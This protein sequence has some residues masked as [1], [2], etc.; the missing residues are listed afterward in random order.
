METSDFEVNNIEDI[1]QSRENEE[2]FFQRLSAFVV[3]TNSKVTTFIDTF[4]TKQKGK[5]V[6]NYK[7]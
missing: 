4:T 3:E 6:I 1:L 7:M 5:F 2:A